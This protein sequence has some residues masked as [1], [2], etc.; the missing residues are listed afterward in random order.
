[1]KKKEIVTLNDQHFII[2]YFVQLLPEGQQSLL[3]LCS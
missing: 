2:V 3:M 1:M